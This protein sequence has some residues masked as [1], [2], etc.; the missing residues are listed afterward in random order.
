VADGDV[1]IDLTKLRPDVLGALRMRFDVE[2]DDD[3]QDANIAELS[4]EE[5]VAEYAGCVLGDPGWGLRLIR[6]YE[7]AQKAEV[8]P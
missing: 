7:D 5:I 1:V 8:K 3:S 4:P 2:E 6:V